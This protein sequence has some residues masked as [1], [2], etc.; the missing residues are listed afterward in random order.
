VDGHVAT[1]QKME[2]PVLDVDEHGIG[3]ISISYTGGERCSNGNFR[4]TKI[5]FLCDYSAEYTSSPTFISE[6]ACTYLFE[7]STPY[8]CPV[9]AREVSSGNECK[10]AVKGQSSPAVP[11]GCLLTHLLPCFENGQR[12]GLDLWRVGAGV[13]VRWEARAL[14]RTALCF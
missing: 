14:C 12:G 5:E 11:G 3:K 10:L 9:G 1:G 2:L 8:A 7:W 6:E 4:S 13:L